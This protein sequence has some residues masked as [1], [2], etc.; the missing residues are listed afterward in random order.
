MVTSSAPRWCTARRQWRGSS[1]ASELDLHVRFDRPAA[2][3]LWAQVELADGTG[4]T[5]PFVVHAAVA[6]AADGGRRSRGRAHRPVSASARPSFT[7]AA[8]AAWSRSLRS[9]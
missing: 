7:A 9:A 6:P 3:R 8:S 1:F 5:A 2:Y 4:V